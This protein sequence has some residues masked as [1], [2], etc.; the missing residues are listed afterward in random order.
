MLTELF[1]VNKFIDDKNMIEKYS[2]HLNK[3]LITGQ[4]PLIQ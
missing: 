2:Q 3:V 1:D 4:S